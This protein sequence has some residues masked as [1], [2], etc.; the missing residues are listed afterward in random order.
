MKAKATGERRK[1]FEARGVDAHRPSPIAPHQRAPRAAFT[2]IEC[3]A[4]ISVLAVLMTFATVL[5]WHARDNARNVRR[6]AD[7]IVRAMQAGE[8]WRTDVRRAVAPPRTMNFEHGDGIA[9]KLGTGEVFYAFNSGAVWRKAGDEEWREFLPRVAA[10]R[11]FSDPH[12]RVPA[13]CWEVAIETRRTDSHVK[14]LFTFLA[15]PQPE[16]KG[17]P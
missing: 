14:P 12:E 9:L 8:R 17:K 13:V 1:A 2:L 3:L 5:I 4:Y 7:D 6:C 10:S 15:A 16:P 11:M